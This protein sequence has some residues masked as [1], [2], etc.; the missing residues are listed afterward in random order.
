L[1]AADFDNDGWMDFMWQNGKELYMN[2]GDMTFTGYDLPFSEGAI[3][4][5]NNDGFLDVQMGSTVYMNT[6]NANNWL[7]VN[8]QG[9]QSNAN[10]IGAR[11]EIYGAWGKQ[12]RE[13]KSGN[14]FS[15]QSSLNAHFGLGTATTIDKIIIRWPSGI[16]DTVNNPSINTP[17]KIVESATLAVNSYTNSEFSMYPIPAKQVLNI[18]TNTTVEMKSAQVFDLNGRSV[19]KSALTNST[20]NV[21]TL[22]TGTYILL[23]KD[24][25]GKDYS[26]KFIKE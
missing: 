13:I 22:Q 16:V 21:E 23:L 10:G 2:N 3:G 7:T 26:E 6:P 24:T 5:L 20:L 15:H 11:V 4:D 12:I 8:L 19:L 1:Q 18:K 9:I 17:I 25:T 14:G